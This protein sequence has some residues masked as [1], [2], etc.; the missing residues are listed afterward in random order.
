MFNLFSKNEQHHLLIKLN[1]HKNEHL[2]KA[3]SYPLAYSDFGSEPYLLG[4]KPNA[5]C[6]CVCVCVEWDDHDPIKSFKKY[7]DF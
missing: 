3:S 1:V 6:V 2:L 7:F 4:H 5:L